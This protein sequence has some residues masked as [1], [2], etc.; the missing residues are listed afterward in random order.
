MTQRVSDSS[1]PTV[2]FTPSPSSLLLHGLR[3]SK[4]FVE[5]TKGFGGRPESPLRAPRT[6]YDLHVTPT[7]TLYVLGVHTH[8]TR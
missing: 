5:D 2:G 3:R 4:D 7:V 1:I 8:T 6:N